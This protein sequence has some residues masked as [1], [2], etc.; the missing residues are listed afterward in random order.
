MAEQTFPAA[1]GSG[2]VTWDPDRGFLPPTSS[3]LVLAYPMPNAPAGWT[4]DL[5]EFHEEIS[6]GQHP[7]DLASLALA[8]E[9]VGRHTPTE[10]RVLEIGCSGGH[11]IRRLRRERP[12]LRVEGADI[13]N[14]P[15]KR[16]ALKLREDGLA[17]PILQFDLTSCPLP[18]ETYDAV[19]AL[20]VLEHIEDHCRAVTEAAR[21]LK[22]NGVFIF[23]VPAGSGLYDDYDREL[24]HYRRYDAPD[25]AELLT[26][27]GLAKVRLSHLGS[28]IYPAFWAVKSWRKKHPK[29]SS[30]DGGQVSEGN[31]KLI[32]LSSGLV[33]KVVF[34]LELLL[35][36]VIN[37]PRGIR[38]FGVFKKPGGPSV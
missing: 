17:T 25:L 24:L 28:F 4:D 10:G 31:R 18:D 33:M 20:N 14:Q 36:R 3:E 27:A 11:L 13:I 16:L 22:P 9:A 38:C 12:E 37:Y 34:S 35:G 15:L 6:G 7:I 19:V 5:T 26:G 1:E 2:Q 8:A 30:P 32:T 21:I 29:S 23:E